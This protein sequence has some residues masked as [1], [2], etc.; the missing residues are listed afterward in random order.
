MITK[1]VG[2]ACFLTEAIALFIIA[3]LKPPQR[4]RFEATKTIKAF[5]TSSLFQE[6]DG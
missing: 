3:E 6:A 4:P 5:L 2:I 1:S